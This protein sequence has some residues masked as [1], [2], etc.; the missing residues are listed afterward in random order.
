MPLY[1][2]TDPRNLNSIKK[3]GLLSWM[4]LESRGIRHYPASNSLSRNLD[5][6]VEL[7]DYA[8]L[9]LH[10]RHPMAYKAV[11]EGR[12]ISFVWLEI[13][14]SVTRW[15]STLFSDE[16]ATSNIAIVDNY[17]STAFNSDSVQAEV[18][19]KSSLNPKWIT[20]P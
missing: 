16:N 4:Q 10:D 12:I 2:F 14:D 5:L 19:I 1:H 7:E 13:D 9:C 6:R 18:L 15:R 17:W 11:Y 3:Y 8:R 20:F